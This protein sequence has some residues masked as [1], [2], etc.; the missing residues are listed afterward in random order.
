MFIGRVNA[1]DQDGSVKMNTINYKILNVRIEQGLLQ[2]NSKEWQLTM[3]NSNDD[4]F[5]LNKQTGEL[6]VGN[7]RN[8]RLLDRELIT[9]FDLTVVAHNPFNETT[10][11]K[12]ETLGQ[13][14][15]TCHII[16]YLNYLNDNI[17]LFDQVN[18]C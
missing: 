12:S 10:T 13:M 8:Y 6:S 2:F 4:L 1:L 9:F 14:T 17:P 18:H 11:D 16:V 15:D 7:S 5:Y 3:L